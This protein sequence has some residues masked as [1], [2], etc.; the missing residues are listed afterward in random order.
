MC[1][2][3]QLDFLK[4]IFMADTRDMMNHIKHTVFLALITLMFAAG[5]TV[6]APQKAEAGWD[7]E[8][9]FGW[10]SMILNDKA[11]ETTNNGFVGSVMFGYRFFDLVGIYIEQDLGFIEPK[12]KNNEVGDHKVEYPKLFK[13]ATLADAQLFFDF[14]ILELSFK[15]GIGTMYMHYK[16]L[17]DVDAVLSVLGLSAKDDWE[18]WFAF[19]AGLGLAV[20]L[21]FFRVGAEFDYTLGAADE[22][23]WDHEDA[24]HFI[25]LK[26]FVG[27]EF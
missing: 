21:G 26:G 19:R 9:A 2:T 8:L 23:K 10:D 12:L 25:S 1:I 7:L 27:F 20:K 3:F 15:L 14:L 5:F 24:S 6:A 17:K 16:T 18:K 13:G 11:F 4:E 22:N